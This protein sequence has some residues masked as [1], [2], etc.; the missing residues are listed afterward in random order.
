MAK[1]TVDS[2]AFVAV[3]RMH[4]I[5]TGGLVEQID[6]LN[7]EGQTL[8]QPVNWD[9][10]LARQFRGDW[11]STHQALLRAKDELETVRQNVEKILEAIK[12]SGG[13]F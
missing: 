10:N 2:E 11:P 1:V 8:S 7:R 9:G 12:T 3:S 5:I 6:S 4:R 13:G